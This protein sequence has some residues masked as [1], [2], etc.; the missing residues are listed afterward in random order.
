MDPTSDIAL[1]EHR[2]NPLSDAQDLRPLIVST[3]KRLCGQ[4]GSKAESE[5]AETGWGTLEARESGLELSVMT[6]LKRRL[7]N[8]HRRLG[9]QVPQLTLICNEIAEAS[10]ETV[11]DFRRKSANSSTH[12]PGSSRDRQVED[13][14][15]SSNSPDPFNHLS[16]SGLINLAIADLKRSVA[17][18]TGITIQNTLGDRDEDVN[19]FL[20]MWSRAVFQSLYLSAARPSATA[21]L[22][23]HIE[24]VRRSF[25]A[26]L[27]RFVAEEVAK[28]CV[29]V[30]VDFQLRR[31]G[32][33]THPPRK[34]VL[35]GQGQSRL[36]KPNV[37]L[38]GPLNTRSREPMPTLYEVGGT[39]D[40][41]HVL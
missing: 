29:E 16:V 41:V 14:D 3:M 19:G 10:L 37:K 33:P 27:S 25:S 1:S 28:A 6:V 36:R 4:L 32:L 13:A 40:S 11:V 15:E 22:K 12:S 8:L 23:R 18:D 26:D 2:F 34:P 24:S 17:K 20:F 7:I 30:V 5:T 31:A 21:V 9:P 35:S 39:D 38:R